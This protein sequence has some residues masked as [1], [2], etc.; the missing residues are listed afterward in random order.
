M[1]TAQLPEIQGAIYRVA[2]SLDA[3]L[4]N[5]LQY[6]VLRQFTANG[7]LQR[8][9]GTLLSDLTSLEE[10]ARRAPATSQLKLTEALAGLR[11]S[12]QRLVDLVMELRSFRTLSLEQLRSTVSQVPVLR[13]ACVNQIQELEACLR[14]PEPFYQSRPAHSAAAVNGFL[15]NLEGVFVQEWSASAEGRG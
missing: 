11:A 6:G 1:N 12:C 2:L 14:T 13:D 8:A 15:T 10:Q 4:V 7:F 5:G 9:A 3:F